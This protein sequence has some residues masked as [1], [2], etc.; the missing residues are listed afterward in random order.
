MLNGARACQVPAVLPEVNIGIK[1]HPCSR[2][3]AGAL[4]STGDRCVELLGVGFS[5]R[6]TIACGAW[7]RMRCRDEAMVQSVVAVEFSAGTRC[8]LK[9]CE[10]AVRSRYCWCC[11]GGAEVPY[12]QVCE[13]RRAAEVS[14]PNPTMELSGC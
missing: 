11:C 4:V 14:A 2:Q 9:R 8:F 12:F 10:A 1:G 7:G 13:G 6:S 5:P 3:S